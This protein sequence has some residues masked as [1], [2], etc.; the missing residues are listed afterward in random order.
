M[1]QSLYIAIFTVKPAVKHTKD[2]TSRISGSA[3]GGEGS[4]GVGGRPPIQ[5]PSV[6][7]ATLR[8]YQTPASLY[9]LQTAVSDSR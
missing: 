7:T 5:V 8:C 1:Q 6:L 9:C 2:S 3:E 4:G